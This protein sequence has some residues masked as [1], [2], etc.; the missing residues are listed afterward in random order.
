MT[1]HNET[2]DK[3]STAREKGGNLWRTFRLEPPTDIAGRR[4]IDDIQPSYLSH[5]LKI[6]ESVAFSISVPSRKIEV[7]RVKWQIRK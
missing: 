2:V 5:I 1:T 3:G 7:P 4:I 6:G